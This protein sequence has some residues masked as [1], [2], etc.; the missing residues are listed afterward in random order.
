MNFSHTN[1][2][3]GCTPRTV[4]QTEMAGIVWMLQ[5]AHVAVEHLEIIS[6]VPLE[7]TKI[8]KIAGRKELRNKE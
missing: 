5:G 2:R 6:S 3:E 4:L 8:L 1:K 7:N